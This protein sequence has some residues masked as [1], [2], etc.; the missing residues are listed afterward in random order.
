MFKIERVKVVLSAAVLGNCGL[1]MPVCAT[2]LTFEILEHKKRKTLW[3]L[4]EVPGFI[5]VN[6]EGAFD[7]TCTPQ[8]KKS[9]PKRERKKKKNTRTVKIAPESSNITPPH[10]VNNHREG[11]AC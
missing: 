1:R 9:L 4:R 11:L 8:E 3:I 7:I 6:K 5:F 2:V 10:W